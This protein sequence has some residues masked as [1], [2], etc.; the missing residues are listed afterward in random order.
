M[1]SD[2]RSA[3]MKLLSNSSR[4][5]DDGIR[6]PGRKSKLVEDLLKLID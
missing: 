1:V 5:C 2:Q 3:S 4:P 6:E